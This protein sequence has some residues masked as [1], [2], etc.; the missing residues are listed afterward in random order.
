MPSNEERNDLKVTVLIDLAGMCKRV[1]EH[2]ATPVRLL[3]TADAMDSQAEILRVDRGFP[4]RMITLVKQQLRSAVERQQRRNALLGKLN[5]KE[6]VW[7][8]ISAL[9]DAEIEYLSRLLLAMES[10]RISKMS[11]VTVFPSCRQS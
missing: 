6:K 3:S 9:H 4:T 5:L 7:Q 1:A 11:R 8:D 2:P 10:S